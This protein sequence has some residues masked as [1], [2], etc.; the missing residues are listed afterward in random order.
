LINLE[1]VSSKEVE[2]SGERNRKKLLLV[3]ECS[4]EAEKKLFKGRVICPFKVL[5]L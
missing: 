2:G 5:F 3:P 4:W 1:V